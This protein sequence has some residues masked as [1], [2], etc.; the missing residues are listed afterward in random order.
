MGWPP[1]VT[2]VVSPTPQ[3][4]SVHNDVILIASQVKQGGTGVVSEDTV[5]VSTR[6][7]GVVGRVDVVVFFVPDLLLSNIHSVKGSI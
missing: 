7:G 5:V 1:V 6:I 4:K 3:P 2:Q